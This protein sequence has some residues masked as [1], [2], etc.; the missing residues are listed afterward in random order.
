MRGGGTT[1]ATARFLFLAI[2]VVLCGA[3]PS[4]P[5]D[6]RRAQAGDCVVAIVGDVSYTVDDSN[7][8]S[9]GIRPMPGE[10]ERRRLL[11][12]VMVVAHHTAGGD[13]PGR[14]LDYDNLLLSYSAFLRN[15]RLHARAG[16]GP[17]R[18]RAIVL[19][20]EELRD[21]YRFAAGPCLPAPP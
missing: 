1:T 18:G 19:R 2:L 4:G 11:A 7:R 15:E 6:F 5:D 3:C 12:D 21:A 20:I 8:L 10:A 17:D 16:T 14:P 13:A 9:A